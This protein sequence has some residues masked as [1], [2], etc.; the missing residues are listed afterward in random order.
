MT[1][2]NLQSL[3]APRPG[4]CVSLYIPLHAGKSEQDSILWWK[5][6]VREAEEL[7]MAAGLRGSETADLFRP[8]SRM[9]G[10]AEFW[11]EGGDGGLRQ[12]CLDHHLRPVAPVEAG[13][14]AASSST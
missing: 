12:A 13:P 5:N 11:R 7:V 6:T 4:P 9:F 3:V 14:P 2:A 1:P 8:A 10:D